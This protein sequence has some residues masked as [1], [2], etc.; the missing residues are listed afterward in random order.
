MAGQSTQEIVAV[1]G[2]PVGGNPT[3]F[4]ME[5][6][7]AQ[8]GL[9]WR[10]LTIEVRPEDLADAVH[11]AKAMRF[12]GFNLTVPHKVDV[13][14][15][16]DRSSEAA[17]LTGAVNCV[18]R[19]EDVLVGENT[20]GKG[21]LEAIRPLVDL[22]GK[23]VVLLGAGGAAR[24]IAVELALAGVQEITIVNRHAERAAPLV[25]LLSQKLQVASKFVPLTSTYEVPAEA[26]ILV[27]ATTV[28]LG[29]RDAKLPIAVK[30]LHK[31]LLV[32]D[33]NFNPPDTRLIRDARDRG[34]QTLTGLSMLVNQAAINFKLWTGLE[35]DKNVM[36]EALEEFL[37]F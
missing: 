11:G 36:G 3:Q 23:R 21:F 29:D 31:E 20:D 33:V 14:P 30:S 4:M 22:S 15:L 18:C 24:A 26:N 1:F 5:K 32:A 2:Q 17:Q 34:C 7:F 27:N 19:D 6:A 37:G 16:L 10:Y 25:D 13:V 35:P 8:A 9:D 28:G 12:R